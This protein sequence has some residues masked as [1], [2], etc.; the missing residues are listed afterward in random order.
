M[1]N[2][3][4]VKLL[5]AARAKRS[6]IEGKWGDI[7]RYI[8]PLQQGSFAQGANTSEGSK[9]WSTLDVW[10]STAPI[11]ADRFAAMLHSVLLSGQ[12][13]GA[14]FRD[15]ALQKNPV[16]KAWLDES[17]LRVYDAIMSSNFEVEMASAVLEWVGYGNTCMTHGLVNDLEWEGFDFSCTPIREVFFEE[18]WRGRPY[19]SWRPLSW[20]ASKIVSKFRDPEDKSKPSKL[21][22]EKILKMLESGADEN[23]EVIFTVYPREGAAPMRYGEKVRAP[24]LRPFA[25]KYVLREGLVTLDEGGFYE[26]PVYLGRYAKSA[27]SMWGYG[28]ALLALPTVKLLN[29]LQETEVNAG[30]KAVDPSIIVTERGLL[31]D[32]DNTPGGLITVRSLDDIDTLESKGRFDVSEL[33]LDRHSGM[34]RKHFREDDI[35]LKDSSMTATEVNR[36]FVQSNRFL[37]LPGKRM[38]H[39]IL[40]PTV[41]NSFSTM[42]R[43][44]QLP[45]IPDVVLK[46]NPRM[47]ILFFG[48][49]VTAQ[50]DDEA[51]GIERALAAKAALTKMDPRSPARFVIKDD[52][53]MRELC[54]RLSTPAT[55]LAT[56]QEVQAA[57]ANEAKLADAAQKAQVAKTAMEAERAGAGAEA[58]RQETEA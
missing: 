50:R 34:V 39:D 23:S 26:M 41:Q 44:D 7:D 55:M 17:M 56:E 42:L 58:L 4:V 22:P 21:I 47:Q 24:E 6:N 51:A 16:A 20:S 35:A 45:T 43:M 49:L 52:I 53:A 8:L 10:D 29:V 33:L 2:T 31:S 57:V 32:F 9:D 40:G 1:E 5:D 38:Q 54:D 3:Q 12:W 27:S 14:K 48:P 13:F 30:A 18:D 19:R 15:S 37:A 46:S 28:P 11:G 25:W 36:R